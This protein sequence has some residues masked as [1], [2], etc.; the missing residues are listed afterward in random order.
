MADEEKKAGNGNAAGG[1][2]LSMIKAGESVRLIKVESGN[3]LRQ[4]MVAMGL[5]PGSSFEVVKNRGDGPV[6][7]CVK[8][9]RLIIGRGMSEK[10]MVSG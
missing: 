6:V 7:L 3:G 1:R 9:T 8:G 4:R 2:P 10:I 5:L